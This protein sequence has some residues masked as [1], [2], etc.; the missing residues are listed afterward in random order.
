MYKENRT[1][2]DYYIYDL[3]K[4]RNNIEDLEYSILKGRLDHVIILLSRGINYNYIV[5]DAVKSE[6]VD[7][8]KY[9]L[10]KGFKPTESSI[11]RASSTGN[12]EM[13][14]ILTEYGSNV[15]AA[16]GIPLYLA[17]KNGYLNIVK[18]LIEHGANK[19]LKESIKVA[20]QGKNFDIVEYLNIYLFFKNIIWL[21]NYIYLLTE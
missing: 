8:V 7:L 19:S 15:N 10:N 12:L 3:I 21:P 5:Y 20:R 14:K 17:S 11:Q 13:I 16:N 9:L 2:Y 6:N 4:L 1:W 18:Y